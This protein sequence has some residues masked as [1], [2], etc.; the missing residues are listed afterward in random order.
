MTKK[1]KP[2]GKT[3]SKWINHHSKG[4]EDIKNHLL[5]WAK[6]TNKNE[7][8]KILKSCE[9]GATTHL[10][11]KGLPHAPF[12]YLVEIED[13]EVW[14]VDE[15]ENKQHKDKLNLFDYLIKVNNLDH[16][17]IEAM[18]GKIIDRVHDIK[19]DCEDKLTQI[20]HLG[21]ESLLIQHYAKTGYDQAKRA[22]KDR[23]MLKPYMKKLAKM[24]G[25]AKQMWPI[26]FG[27]LD[28]DQMSP[29]EDSDGTR[30][31]YICDRTGKEGYIT[32]TTFE[33]K[34]STERNKKF[35]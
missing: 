24:E 31:D 20:F 15:P 28:G 33:K 23:D 29:E 34:L 12:H 9:L 13:K 7:F 5:D 26:L 19:S 4:D 3:Y 35:R 1:T 25:S 14:Q 30:Y 32:F 11:S 22:S 27:M 6:R 2:F 17:C 18:A 10:K 8:N 21:K 16:D